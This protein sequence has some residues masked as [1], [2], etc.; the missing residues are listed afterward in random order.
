MAIEINI[1]D[2]FDTIKDFFSN[3]TQEVAGPA[4]KAAINETLRTGRKEVLQEIHKRVYVNSK[5]KTRSDFKNKNTFVFKATGS[6]PFTMSGALAFSA[7]P[8]PLL[9]FARGNVDNIK[10][11]GIKVAKRKKTKIEIYKGRKFTLKKGFIQKH[12]S[13]QVFKNPGKDRRLVKQ[14]I[15]SI[16][17]LIENEPSLEKKIVNLMKRKFTINLKR[18]LKFRLDKRAAKARGVRPKLRK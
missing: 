3:A 8:L 15:P 7:S 17:K 11:K 6:N 10:Q 18:Q 16:S 1:L 5:V 12:H 2:N 9:L 13:K 14:A 4:V